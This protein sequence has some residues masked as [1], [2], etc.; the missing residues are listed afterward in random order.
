MTFSVLCSSEAFWTPEF[1]V[2]DSRVRFI[3]VL[4]NCGL[5]ICADL[6]KMDEIGVPVDLYIYDLTK[7]MARLMSAMF[8]GMTLTILNSQYPFDHLRHGLI[9][10]IC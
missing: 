6:V 3:W 5:R 1:V 4:Y 9:N 8:L 7:G 10:R 2:I